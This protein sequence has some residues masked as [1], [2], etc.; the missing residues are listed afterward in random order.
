MCVNKLEKKP[1]S[2]PFQLQQFLEF[3][4]GTSIALCHLI[5]S[6]FPQVLALF[7]SLNQQKQTSAAATTDDNDQLGRQMARDT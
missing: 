6:F 5:D 3:D 2:F 1:F 7:F 4:R